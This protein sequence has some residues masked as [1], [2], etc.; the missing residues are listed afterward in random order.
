MMLVQLRYLFSVVTSCP[1]SR[2]PEAMLLMISSKHSLPHGNARATLNLMLS[3]VNL[4]HGF[5]FHWMQSGM[6]RQHHRFNVC[7]RHALCNPY[8]FLC[9]V[10]VVPNLL[11]C[12]AA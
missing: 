7:S 10:R 12:S 5:W 9:A 2:N 1:S 3:P 6:V 11:H 4:T 8:V